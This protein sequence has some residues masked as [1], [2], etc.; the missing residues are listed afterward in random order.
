MGYQTAREMVIAIISGGFVVTF[1]AAAHQLFGYFPNIPSEIT[2]EYSGIAVVLFGFSCAMILVIRKNKS[3][4]EQ[5]WEENRKS[6]VKFML[7]AVDEDFIAMKPI[8]EKLQSR[9]FDFNNENE[10]VTLEDVNEINPN[11]FK[12][13]FDKLP[14]I[15]N[16]LGFI[17]HEQYCTLYNYMKDSSLFIDYLCKQNYR[18]ELLES[19]AEEA[20]KI[21]EFFGYEENDHIGIKEWKKR[22]SQIDQSIGMSRPLQGE[23]L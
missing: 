21:I 2:K 5:K 23:K 7:S 22:L 14:I 16:V 13:R 15:Q 19:R 17:T 6:I 1:Q 3:R 9:G 12:D 10:T 8:I 20:K 18:K 11:A 4:Y